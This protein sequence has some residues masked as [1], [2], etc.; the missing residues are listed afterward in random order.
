MSNTVSMQFD[1]IDSVL[2]HTTPFDFV[3]GI[4]LEELHEEHNIDVFI[5]HLTSLYLRWVRSDIHLARNAGRKKIKVQDPDYCSQLV[6]YCAEQGVN[7]F[8]SSMLSEM[9]KH[10]EE[11]RLA[12]AKGF[13]GQLYKR[14]YRENP[15]AYWQDKNLEPAFFDMLYLVND[16][17]QH[18][19]FEYVYQK[20]PFISRDT[21]EEKYKFWK[22][23]IHH[24]GE[25]NQR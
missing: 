18:A 17:T 25:V 22:K 20:Y 15:R 21:F 1:D 16:K 7:L 4:L 19:A 6:L 9:V 2:K 13:S 23:Y 5:P 3:S 10:T 12:R 14:H 11:L 24:S 8:K